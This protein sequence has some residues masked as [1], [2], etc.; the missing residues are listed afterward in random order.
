MADCQTRKEPNQGESTMAT[1]NW[2]G[3]VQA[4]ASTVTQTAP[5]VLDQHWNGDGPDG[6]LNNAIQ[7]LQDVFSVGTTLAQNVANSQ[8]LQNPHPA[9][10]AAA[11]QG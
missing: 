8:A 1:T 6:K 2:Q 4:A 10:I 5:N 11:G 9:L 7:I 3:I